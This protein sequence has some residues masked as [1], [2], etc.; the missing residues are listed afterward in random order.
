MKKYHVSL[1]EMLLVREIRANIQRQLLREGGRLVCFTMNI[2]GEIKR[3]PLVR[4]L[5]DLSLIHI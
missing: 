3:T 4:M 2:P 1:N 5:F